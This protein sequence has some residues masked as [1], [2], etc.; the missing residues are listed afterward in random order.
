MSDDM[1]KDDVMPEENPSGA[2][3]EETE[4]PEGEEHAM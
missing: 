2:P 1:N 4:T 3:E